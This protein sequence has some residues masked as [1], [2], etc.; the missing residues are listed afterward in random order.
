MK[1]QTIS[2]HTLLFAMALM[3]L[4][5]LAGLMSGQEAAKDS[6]AAIKDSKAASKTLPRTPGIQDWSTHHVNFSAPESAEQA[7]KD[8]SAARLKALQNNTRYKMVMAA[9]AADLVRKSSGATSAVT[10]A[11]TA[12]EAESLL[13]SA[14]IT[15]AATKFSPAKTTKPTKPQGDWN[16]YLGGASGAGVSNPWYPAKYTWDIYGAPSCTKDAVVVPINKAVTN[17]TTASATGDVGTIT[18]LS[19]TGSYSLT[20]QAGAAAGLTLNS[21]PPMKASASGMFSGLPGNGNTVVIG[22]QTFTASYDTQATNGSI[23]VASSGVC[24]GTG[25]GVSIHGTLL[26]TS[27]TEGT[28][29]ITVGSFSTFPVNN[30]TIKIPNTTSGTTYTFVTSTS[31]G[32]NQ[33][34]IATSGGNTNRDAAATNLAAALNG[35]CTATECGTSTTANTQVSATTVSGSAVTVSARCANN[36]TM[37]MANSSSGNVTVGGSV[38]A[39]TG[40][41]NSTTQFQLNTTAGGGVSQSLTAAGILY[42]INHNTTTDA[43]VTAT[44]GAPGVTDLAAITWGTTGNYTVS[45]TATSGV[46][47]ASLTNGA[48]GTQSSSSFIIDNV[49]AD[50]ATNLAASITS[51]G[52]TGVTPGHSGATLTLT[53][54]TA[55]TGGNSLGG[56]TNGLA[57]FNLPNG[58]LTGGS[59]GT[60]SPSTCNPC[61]FS[62]WSGST[63][64]T[65]NALAGT[66]ATLITNN[67]ATSGVTV[68]SSS[69]AETT[70]TS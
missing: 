42:V 66:L 45:T 40:G 65:S 1:Q 50:A 20:V 32:T 5:G 22:G 6:T 57:S 15:S 46:T 14:G 28:A 55:G 35:T 12:D 10:E 59:D 18:S 29:T 8:G 39:G 49:P 33:I 61:T 38:A 69:G 4:I 30:E 54:P 9:R 58:N 68:S 19:A 26:T 63:P 47:F 70:I 21:S 13:S 17:E 24:I 31:P 52:L 36:A 64:V 60:T 41:N 43:I 44:A 23:T 37:V 16:N 7:Q 27:A 25:Q 56:V 53:A 48:S 34:H 67:P 62:Y 51:N 2:K 11:P 3:T